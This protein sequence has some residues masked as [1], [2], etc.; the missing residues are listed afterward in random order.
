MVPT[1]IADSIWNDVKQSL[2]FAKASF[3]HVSAEF[4]PKSSNRVFKLAL[5]NYGE[6]ILLPELLAKLALR[7]PLVN[8]KLV[9][10]YAYEHNSA[11]EAGEI[12]LAIDLLASESP[13]LDS[14]LIMEEQFV[15]IVSRTHP[16]F[17]E[18]MNLDLIAKYGLI[19]VDLNTPKRNIFIEKLDPKQRLPEP[20]LSL[21]NPH[22]IPSIIARNHHVGLLTH[23]LALKSQACQDIRIFLPPQE[24]FKFPVHLFWHKKFANDAGN[25]WLRN[26]LSEICNEQLEE[27]CLV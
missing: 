24:E 22:V 16:E 26:L 12:D 23:L 20:I 18:H 3:S 19:R 21:H 9:R 17:R 11:L 2:Q 7:A 4:D 1:S 27:G 5:G 25:L 8:L 13:G 14:E 6:A 10:G 15:F